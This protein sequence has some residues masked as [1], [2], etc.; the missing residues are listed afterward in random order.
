[1][2]STRKQLPEG[3]QEIW[4]ADLAKNKKQ[5][6]LVNGLA[7]ALAVGTVLVP[8]LGRAAAGSFVLSGWQ[9]AVAAVG[10]LFY[11]PLHELVH[12]LCMKGFGAGKIHYGY[13]GVYAWAGSNDFFKK[14][15]YIVIA[16]APLVSLGIALAC[17]CV[18]VPHNWFWAV[19]LIQVMNISGAAGDIYVAWKAFGMPED[20]LVQD[21]GT[22]MVFYSRARYNKGE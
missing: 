18:F 13:A 10:L 2:K 7:L 17:L 5:A 1:M 6:L 8:L 16:L 9:M 19:Y 4:R 3:Y 11:I 21:T 14:W 20:L 22:A 15:P 12:G